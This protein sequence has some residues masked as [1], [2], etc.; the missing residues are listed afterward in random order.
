MQPTEATRLGAEA[1]SREPVTPGE[2]VM[3]VNS[4]GKPSEPRVLF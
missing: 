1:F 3:P 4:L 2:P